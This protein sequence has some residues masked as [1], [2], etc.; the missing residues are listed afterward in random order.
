M[1]TVVSF[2]CHSRRV[3]EGSRRVAEGSRRVAEGSR[4]VAEGSRRVAEGSRRV[5]EG[6]R[7][8]AHFYGNS[9]RNIF[10]FKQSIYLAVR[11]TILKLF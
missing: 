5:A 6:S 1:S 3:A 4:R 11:E 7:R 2:V 10:L 9:N 8:V